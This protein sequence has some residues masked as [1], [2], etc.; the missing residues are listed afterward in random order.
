MSGTRLATLENFD[1][2]QDEEVDNADASGT[3][4]LALLIQKFSVYLL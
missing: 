4:L 3:Q 1:S 2:S